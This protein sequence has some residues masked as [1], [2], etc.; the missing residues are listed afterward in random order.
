MIFLSEFCPWIMLYQLTALHVVED[1]V[2]Y[3]AGRKI[4]WLVSCFL[5]EPPPTPDNKLKEIPLPSSGETICLCFCVVLPLLEFRMLKLCCFV[6]LFFFFFQGVC[7]FK[8]TSPFSHCCCLHHSLSLQ[9][10]LL[11]ESKCYF[12]SHF[13]PCEKT[14]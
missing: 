14:K 5:P 12:Q 3:C 13:F 1:I 10:F 4:S 6:G 7:V 8:C 2:Q 9:F 11:T